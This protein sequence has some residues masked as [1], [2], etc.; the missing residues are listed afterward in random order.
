MVF[1]CA[2]CKMCA[3]IRADARFHCIIADGS[4]CNHYTLTD[5]FSEQETCRL[6]PN[7]DY[8][9]VSEADRVWI[10]RMIKASG[11]R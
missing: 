4:E 6:T 8:F 1:K 2:D 7:E 3:G 11:R 9:E 10:A 5:A